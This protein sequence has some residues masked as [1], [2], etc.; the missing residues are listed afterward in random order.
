MAHEKIVNAVITGAA[1]QIDHGF[2]L[3][4]WLFLD[5]GGTSQ[6]FGGYV[7]GGTSGAKCANHAEQ[8]N[9]AAEFIVSCMRAGDVESF[10]ALKGKTIRVKVNGDCSARNI[11]AIGHIIK[12]DRWFN[13]QE[14]LGQMQSLRKQHRQET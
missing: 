5:Y 14:R 10:S 8:P 1:I 11:V 7:L 13:P 6:G 2:A 12:D 3:S 9:I 4:V